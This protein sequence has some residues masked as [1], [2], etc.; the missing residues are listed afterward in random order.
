[1]N[2][3]NSDGSVRGFWNK[4]ALPGDNPA[5]VQFHD[6]GMIAGFSGGRGPPGSRVTFADIDGD[7]LADVSTHGFIGKQAC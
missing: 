5:K 2:I 4:G 6:A 7:G 3:V 1:M